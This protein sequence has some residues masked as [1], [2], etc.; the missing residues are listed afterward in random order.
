MTLQYQFRPIDAWPTTRTVN[1]KKSPFQASWGKTLGMLENELGHLQ[2]SGVVIQA[3]VDASKI[4]N[5]GMLYASAKPSQPGVILSFNSKH[6]PLLYPCDT[7]DDWQAN[8]RAIALSLE[9][10]R[11]VDRY[12]VTKRAEQYKGFEKLEG[13]SPAD[14]MNHAAKV[15]CNAAGYAAVKPE[16]LNGDFLEQVYRKAATATHPDHGGTDEKFKAVESAYRILA[17]TK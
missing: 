6:G 13:P 2:A 4:R 14:Q 8:V 9:A 11:K 5:D 17:G 3:Y 7:F 1:R 10:L 16:H 15:L 12:G